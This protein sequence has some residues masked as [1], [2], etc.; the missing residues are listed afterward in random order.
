MEK[1]IADII[2]FNANVLTLDHSCPRA[3][4]IAI[5]KDRILAISK[6]NN[7]DAFKG[8]NTRVMDCEGRT[9]L[10]GFNDA[11]CH[12]TAFAESLLTP[13]IGPSAVRSI[14]D[15]QQK[16]NKLSLKLPPETWI[17]ARGY[18]EFYLAEKRHP[19]RWDLDRATSRHPVKL[20]HRSGHA[21]VLNSL[22][23]ALVGISGTTPDPPRGFIERDLET[24]EPNGLLYGMQE[25][26]A[27]AIPP[28][29]NAELVRGVKL[30]TEELLSS[31]ITSI[32]DASPG[33]DAR[34]WHMLQQ[35]IIQGH[36]KCRV[37]MLLGV[38]AFKQHLQ[39]SL[40]SEL[41][42]DQFKLSGVK[43]V[44]DRTTGQLNPNQEELNRIVFEIHQSG[45][46]AALHAIEEPEVEACC[47]ALEYA[48]SRSP[49]SQHRH[50]IEHCSICTPMDAK[51]LASL[52][53]MV[54]T[55]PAFVYYS[56]E[57]YLETV[58]AQQLN[59]L[60]P[61]ATLIKAGVKVAASS[62]C[63]IIPP[64]PRSGIYAAVTRKADNGQSVL[65]QEKISVLDALQIYTLGSAYASF[66]ENAKGS[67]SPGK[68]ADLVVLN[69]DPTGIAPEKIRDLRITLTMVGGEIAWASD[70]S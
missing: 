1:T 19:S 33:N 40:L 67:I 20:T 68:F 25:Y 48:L 65:I 42:P 21:H 3:R 8:M 28:L 55:Q 2:L 16:I 14:A 53:A 47:S 56:G 59:H 57:R 44:V 6:D 9:V 29:D 36:L 11:H 69:G 26:L 64:D 34:R 24:G 37:S 61:L 70:L 49:K 30:A 32:Q 18:N 12:F 23:L 17:R 15:I 38:E 50:R 13:D 63:P 5:R 43:I 35:W 58:P 51:R 22:A 27:K 62:D 54:V 46:Q 52:E 10:P 31:G 39:R 7:L 66:D 60:Y 4:L 45:I 41:S